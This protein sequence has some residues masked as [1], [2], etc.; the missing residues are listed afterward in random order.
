MKTGISSIITERKLPVFEGIRAV[1]NA[2]FDAI[3]FSICDY[4]WPGNAN[5][6][7]SFLNDS[8]K[9]FAYKLKSE[10][11]KNNL[12]VYQSHGTWGQTTDL[13]EFISPASI[14]YRQLEIAKILGNSYIV[15]HPVL[16]CKR[17]ESLQE[18]AQYIQYNCRWFS[19]LAESAAK[20][21]MG[22]AVENVFSV[23][24]NEPIEGLYPFGDAES[25]LQ[26]VDK[27]GYDK[28]GICL[29]TG[30]ANLEVGNSIVPM[31][32]LCGDKIKVLHIN[33]NMGRQSLMENA[34][35]HMIPVGQGMN[36]ESIC[37]ALKE[38]GFDGQKK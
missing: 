2:G 30:H 21:D 13:S 27:V 15:F 10:F 20:Y 1:A 4:S 32:H 34:D 11:E 14:L 31:I 35:L 28:M 33:D 7:E 37:Q 26:I 22:I 17:V 24:G 9:E 5:Q 12:I 36:M 16:P 38:N 23:N 25:L 3:D 6:E 19:L 18:R 29:D 8:W